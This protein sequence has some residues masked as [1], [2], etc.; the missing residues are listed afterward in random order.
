MQNLIL[1]IRHF[2]S[3][4]FPFVFLHFYASYFY[5]LSLWDITKWWVLNF[6]KV[7]HV[8]VYILGLFFIVL[9]LSLSFS[10]FM[11][12]L[13]L[14]LVGDKQ[15]L[16]YLGHKSESTGVYYEI[17]DIDKKVISGYDVDKMYNT[18]FNNIYRSQV[19]KKDPVSKNNIGTKANRF[20][21]Y[22]VFSVTVGLLVF[23]LAGAVIL[24]ACVYPVYI[25]NPTD[26][27][28]PLTGAQDAFDV[29]INK[30]DL[31]KGWFYGFMLILLFVWLGLIILIPKNNNSDLLMPL[32]TYIK[33]K[34]II[35]GIPN[36]LQIRY[37]ERLRN[38]SLNEYETVDSGERFV[39]FEFTK[40][41]SHT[42][43]VVTIIDMATHADLVGVIEQNIMY[44]KPMLLTVDEHR[45]I[46]LK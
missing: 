5:H 34:A 26:T 29:I 31:S 27:V 16:V 15:E 30:Y 25:S 9:V 23:S 38:N 40:G 42:V 24:N 14:G 7:D 43:Y 20:H 3:L 13:F 45:G 10:G 17:N 21:I 11:N 1:T 6:S 44:K 39:N 8:G 46:T 32:P 2:I 35:E 18:T 37:I 33:D 19:F 36:E 22:S 12:V 41:F 28:L 4:A